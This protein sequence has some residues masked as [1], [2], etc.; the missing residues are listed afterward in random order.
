MRR[1]CFLLVTGV[2]LVTSSRDTGAGNDE[3]RALILQAMKVHG[4][5][6]VLKKYL[7]AQAKYKGTIE[8]GAIS[9][10][11]DGEVFF[12]FP[13]RMKHVATIEIANSMIP[14]VQVFDGT[15]M[16]MSIAG[17]S[18]ELKDQEAVAEIKERLHA[19]QVSN[20]VDLDRKEFS[21]AALGDMKIK[22]RDAVGVRVSKEGRRDVNLWIDKQTYRLLKSE[23]RGKEPPN[24]NG[25]EL[26]QERYGSDYKDVMGILTPH[27]I[28]VEYDGKKAV[29]MDVAEMRYHERLDD[30]T[31]ARP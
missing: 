27:R 20:L 12:Q 11:V 24:F 31:F 8:I 1:I 28:E 17:V 13:D 7:G 19:E 2:A 29:A 6:D 16:W 15:K 9:A 5:K 18:V 3:T 25:P 22:D 30:A 10:K 26:N 14:L 4:G 23:F 21:F